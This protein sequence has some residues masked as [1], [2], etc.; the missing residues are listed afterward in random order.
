MLLKG[1]NFADCGK[2]DGLSLVSVDNCD[3]N[4]QQVG[5][6]NNSDSNKNKNPLFKKLNLTAYS[7]KSADNPASTS[8]TTPK[9]NSTLTKLASALN[10]LALS[11]LMSF[12]REL[13][14][15]WNDPPTDDRHNQRLTD[16]SLRFLEA[17]A[18]EMV[19]EGMKRCEAISMSHEAFIIFNDALSE[20]FSDCESVVQA[21]SSVAPK[22][23]LDDLVTDAKLSEVRRRMDRRIDAY[24]P[25]FVA[26]LETPLH[27]AEKD[28]DKGGRPPE[29]NWED[30]EAY[31]LAQFPNGIPK[32]HGMKAKI[33]EFMELWL[34]IEERTPPSL[35]QL[36]RR[37]SQIY[38]NYHSLRK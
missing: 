5:M 36:Q 4:I 31:A 3:L 28:R 8:Q 20:S 24:R 25:R 21:Y 6:T 2:V 16:R 29:S 33:R 38:N 14:C 1:Y 10:A 15:Y 13:Q 35:R 30:M 26:V 37:S 19:S 17:N 9:P 18:V 32:A 22:K 34:I 27:R 23:G 12:D 11:N 7:V